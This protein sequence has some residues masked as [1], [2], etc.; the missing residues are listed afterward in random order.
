MEDDRNQT[1]IFCWEAETP[2]DSDNVTF[3][4]NNNN[5]KN[6]QMNNQL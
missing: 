3:K 5:K 4:K 2:E 1:I 6:I